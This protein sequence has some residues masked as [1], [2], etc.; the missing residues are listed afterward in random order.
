MGNEPSVPQSA[1]ESGLKPP[2]PSDVGTQA[3]GDSGFSSYDMMGGG[4]PA[5][6]P[7]TNFGG[8][9]YSQNSRMGDQGFPATVGI[10]EDG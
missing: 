10:K 3:M 6:S 8:D 1:P 2:S 9:P 4:P 7:P 5:Q